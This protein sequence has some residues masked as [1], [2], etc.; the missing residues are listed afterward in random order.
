MSA[1]EEITDIVDKYF[2][3]ESVYN[4]ANHCCLCPIFKVTKYS[5][6][7]RNFWREVNTEHCQSMHW[8]FERERSLEEQALLRLLTVHDFINYMEI[9]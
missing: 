3:V 1:R 9:Q 2:W 7:F 8:Y 6:R 5:E 4:E